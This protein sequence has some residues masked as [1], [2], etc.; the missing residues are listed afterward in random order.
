MPKKL[1]ESQL[2]EVRFLDVKRH[3]HYDSFRFRVK[4]RMYV[5]RTHTPHRRSLRRRGETRPFFHLHAGDQLVA[6][7]LGPED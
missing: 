5:S 3:R 2:T 6:T 1:S 4:K 7:V